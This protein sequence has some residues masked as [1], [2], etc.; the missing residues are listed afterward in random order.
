MEN[1]GHQGGVPRQSAGFDEVVTGEAREVILHAK[2]SLRGL[3]SDAKRQ[4]AKIDSWLQKTAREGL[5]R[6][7]EVWKEISL[8]DMFHSPGRQEASSAA[9]KQKAPPQESP[10]GDPSEIYATIGPDE[11]EHLL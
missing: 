7:Q 1:P 3:S 8:G 11:H 5:A 2:E 4:G 6:G 9:S 10:L